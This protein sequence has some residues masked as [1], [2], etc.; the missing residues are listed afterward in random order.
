[1]LKADAVSSF[2]AVR[3]TEP[4]H[5]LSGKCE[6]RR[7]DSAHRHTVSRRQEAVIHSM[8]IHA[9]ALLPASYSNAMSVCVQEPDRHDEMLFVILDFFP[10]IIISSI[11][12][13]QKVY[14][15]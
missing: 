8:S 7:A 5:T 4:T 9:V 11:I 2:Q 14:R 6:E 1:M 12:V 15:S 3:Q 13:L 10:F